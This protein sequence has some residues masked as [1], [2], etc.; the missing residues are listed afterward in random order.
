LQSAVCSATGP[1]LLATV[2]HTTDVLAAHKC[3]IL[4]A[5]QNESFHITTHKIS[6]TLKAASTISVLNLKYFPCGA[7]SKNFTF[8]KLASQQHM[9]YIEN[10]DYKLLVQ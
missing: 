3:A 5:Q 2:H 6:H 10:L 8:T 4:P 7:Q 9:T 1:S